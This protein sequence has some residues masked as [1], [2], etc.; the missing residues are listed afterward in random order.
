MNR[1]QN[2]QPV[3]IPPRQALEHKYASARV[4]LLFMVI[5]TTLNVFL[6]LIQAGVYLLFAAFGPMLITD[7]G[8]VSYEE[9]K[10]VTYIIICGAIALASIVP[11]LV[12][13]LFSKKHVG[14]MIGALVYFSMD[15]L[16]LLLFFDVSLILNIVFHVWVLYYLIIGVV[17]GIK[18]QNMPPE[19]PVMGDN[20]MGTDNEFS[21]PTYNQDFDN[22]MGNGDQNQDSDTQDG[23]D[24][25]DNP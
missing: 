4:N 2:H 13:W 7:I 8:M 25:Q 3:R 19:Q 21:F 10:D 9:T 20:G 18:L 6:T 1:Q 5:I 23:Q 24:N 16:L 17:S 12:C 15:S 22:A 14:W 11:Y